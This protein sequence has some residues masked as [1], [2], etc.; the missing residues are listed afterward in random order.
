[1]KMG[2]LFTERFLEP[3]EILIINTK[4]QYNVDNYYPFH[5]LHSLQSKLLIL[6]PLFVHLSLV[7]AKVVCL[8]ILQ[9][10]SISYQYVY[11]R[12]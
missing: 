2:P 1:M 5:D 6:K 3:L 8:L 9:C 11:K 4:W 7:N 12:I 10:N